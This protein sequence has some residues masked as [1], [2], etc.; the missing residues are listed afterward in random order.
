MGCSSE[1]VEEYSRRM[2]KLVCFVYLVQLVCL[3]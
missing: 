2:L 3:V 1:A